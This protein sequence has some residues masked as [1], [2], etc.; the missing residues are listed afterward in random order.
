MGSRGSS[1]ADLRMIGCVVETGRHKE[2]RAIDSVLR[3]SHGPEARDSGTYVCSREIF[4]PQTRVDRGTTLLA[5]AGTFVSE[6]LQTSHPTLSVLSS[7]IWVI[8]L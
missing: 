5:T 6:Q 8:R 7:D 4:R 1:V 2:R 3:Q